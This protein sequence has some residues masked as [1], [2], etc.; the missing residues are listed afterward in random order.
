[1][2]QRIWISL[3]ALALLLTAALI[4]VVP[5]AGQTTTT[6]TP[7]GPTNETTALFVACSDKAILNVSGTSLVGWDV[8]YQVFSAANATGT[9]LTGIRQVAVA[10][11]YQLSD[12]VTYTGGTAA[13][14]QTV[15][16]RV[17]VGREADSS[18]VDYEFNVNDVQD[19]CANPQFTAT[20][21]TDIS[22][23][24]SAS[25]SAL[26]GVG[27]GILGPNGTILNPNLGAEADVVIG[28]RTSDRFRSET[29][30]LVFA[31]CDAYALAEPGLIYDN[32]SVTVFWSWYTK[33][34]AEMEAHL[35]NAVYDVRLNTAALP[36]TTRSEPVRRDGNYWVF[37]TAN[38]GYL[39]PGHYEVGYE[40]TWS[41]PVNDGY[42]DYGPG[43]ARSILKG[44]CNFD[45]LVNPNG[46]SV[47][48][49]G[50]YF[51]TI[52]PVH[53]INTD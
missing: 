26:Y 6:T 47:V 13:A 32:D 23:G 15:S 24:A 45:I 14:A 10:G 46:A 53:N 2:K 17:W 3:S 20:T 40:L 48:Y 7:T 33:T 37:Y 28:A 18:V 19:G 29:P 1:M 22:D 52:G 42:D 30:G 11:E 38:I 16:A 43:T 31:E 9:A 4:S 27:R 25:S 39:R 49:S 12:T 41:N 21:G 44:L 5:A 36:M 35:A 50:L 51:P 8:Y 34:P